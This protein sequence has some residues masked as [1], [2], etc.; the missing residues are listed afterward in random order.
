MAEL[1]KSGVFL[2][3]SETFLEFNNRGNLSVWLF[4]F[5]STQLLEYRQFQGE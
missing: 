2:D 3:K 4:S 1:Q 5:K